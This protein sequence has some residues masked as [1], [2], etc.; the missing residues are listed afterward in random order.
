MHFTAL[1]TLTPN[2]RTPQFVVLVTIAAGKYH[3][4]LDIFSV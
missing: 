2:S 4:L 1:S 3:H